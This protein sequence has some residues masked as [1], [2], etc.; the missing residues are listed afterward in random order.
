[1][2]RNLT[3]LERL[4]GTTPEDLADMRHGKTAD[5]R[6][7]PYAVEILSVD[8]IIPKSIAPELD[9]RRFRLQCKCGLD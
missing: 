1:M 8:H 7:G 3:I 2:V 4:G 9:N 6:K 5:V